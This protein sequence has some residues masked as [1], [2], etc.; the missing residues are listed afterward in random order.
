MAS[1]VKV[2]EEV[3]RTYDDIKKKKTYRFLIFYIKDEKIICVEKV[4]DRSANYN[5][6]LNDLTGA[7]PDD[8]RSVSSPKSI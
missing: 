1:G 5:D 8:C 6:F 2:D 3:R 4:G 7:G